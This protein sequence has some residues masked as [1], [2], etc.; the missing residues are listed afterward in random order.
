MKSVINNIAA[1]AVLAA[2]NAAKVAA[3]R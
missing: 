1:Q 2:F 3:A